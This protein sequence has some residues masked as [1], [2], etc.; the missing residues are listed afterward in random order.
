MAEVGDKVL[1]FTDGSGK[2]WLEETS[3][4]EVGDKGLVISKDN[5]NLF[6]SK[7]EVEI[8]DKCRVFDIGG[9][10]LV[11]GKACKC[12]PWENQ[13]CHEYTHL[14]RQTRNCIPDACASEERYISDPSC[15]LWYK[16]YDMYHVTNPTMEKNVD[17]PQGKGLQIGGY[18]RYWCSAGWCGISVYI[19][20]YL[21]TKLYL[22]DP[23]TLTFVVYFDSCFDISES[24]TSNNCQNIPTMWDNGEIPSYGGSY[25]ADLGLNS[26]RVD[27]ITDVGY[28]TISGSNTDWIPITLEP[29]EGFNGGNMELQFHASRT[30]VKNGASQWALGI[31]M[32]AGFAKIK[33]NNENVPM[34]P[35]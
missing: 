21:S 34:N 16:Y 9:K 19:S 18:R 17:T 7:S 8:N 3:T 4:P 27:Y 5:T 1:V 10:Y 28:S 12:T 22:D 31:Y 15:P 24:P 26:W 35:L 33:L 25:V 6:L 23:K 32:H 14:R 13:E 2:Y 29:P 20:A 30:G 11:R